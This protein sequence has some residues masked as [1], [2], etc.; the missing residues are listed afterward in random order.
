M[1]VGSNVTVSLGCQLGLIT[2]FTVFVIA[3]TEELSQCLLR[4]QIFCDRGSLSQGV[5]HV[6]HFCRRAF[7]RAT[8]VYLVFMRFTLCLCCVYEIHIRVFMLC[9]SLLQSV[10]IVFMNG[11]RVP[12]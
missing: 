7:S 5:R 8:C 11:A 12:D 10:Y 6:M 2:A 4:L 9:L 3:F 1:A